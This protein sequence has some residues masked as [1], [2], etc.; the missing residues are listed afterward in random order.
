MQEKPKVQNRDFIRVGKSKIQGSGVFA[1]RKIPKGTRIIEYAGD[2]I[3][4]KDLLSDVENGLTS[5]IYVLS[6]NDELSVDGERNGNDA[7]FINHSCEPNC[8]VYIFDEIPYIYAMV[9]IRRFEELTFDYK[10]QSSIG[11]KLTKKEKIA[12]FPC[13]CQSKQC[14]GTILAK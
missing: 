3:P 7:R 5:H 11:T 9:D 12:L 1:K 14:R 4:K 2:R 8:E 10:L 13:N 6:I